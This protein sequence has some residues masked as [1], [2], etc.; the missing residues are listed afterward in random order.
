[1]ARPART[2]W[3]LIDS[4][5]IPPEASAA[6]DEAILNARIRGDVPD[7]VHFYIRDRPSVSIGYNKSVADSINVDEAEKR[8]VAI[9]RRLSGGS[10]VYTDSGQLI[11]SLILSGSALPSDISESYG[12]VCSAVVEGLSALGVMAEHKPINDILV[13]G[14][15]ISG[16]AQLRRGGAILH[17]GTLM[18]DT[19]IDAIAAVIRSPGPAKRL[20]CLRELLGVAPDMQ[21]VKRS[22]AKGIEDSF[23]VALEP[24]ALTQSETAE[25]EK[26]VRE[27]YA[28][29]EWNCRL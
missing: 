28:S 23:N 8:G 3:R 25:I 14:S 17:H 4:G 11:F 20:A 5:I 12:V 15:K 13:G 7:T 29:R 9:V 10:A 22:I 19:D 21:I 24:A 27:K 6:T 26:L 16:S 2:V 1:M 18:V